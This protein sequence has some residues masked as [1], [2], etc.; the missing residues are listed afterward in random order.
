MAET[1][2][3]LYVWHTFISILSLYS[4][5]TNGFYAAFGFPYSYMYQILGSCGDKSAHCAH[6]I[7]DTIIELCFLVDIVLNFFIEYKSDDKLLPV[8]D[9][10]LIAE[11]YLKSTFMLDFLAFTPFVPIIMSLQNA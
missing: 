11:R 6:I 1:N 4:V 8:R 7:Q 9:L 3:F 5:I 2:K 10:A